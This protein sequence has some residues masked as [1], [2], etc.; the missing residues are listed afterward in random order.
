MLEIDTLACTYR[1]VKSYTIY[2]IKCKREFCIGIFFSA[3]HSNI[4]IYEVVFNYG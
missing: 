1:L 4:D 3:T 2:K